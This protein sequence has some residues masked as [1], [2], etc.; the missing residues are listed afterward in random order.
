[1]N[2]GGLNT[3][4]IR[5][6]KLSE[7]LANLDKCILLE[8][9]TEYV[10]YHNKQRN[11]GHMF[12][13][14]RQHKELLYYM[15]YAKS[16]LLTKITPQYFTQLL[17]WRNFDSKEN[18]KYLPMYVITTYMVKLCPIIVSDQSQ[19]DRGINFWLGIMEHAARNGFPYGL[20]DASTGNYVIPKP[21]EKFLDF[22][23]RVYIAAYGR[24][25]KDETKTKY[26]FF[27][28]LTKDG[29]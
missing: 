24:Q 15:E 8:A 25:E 28:Y 23:Q 19:T 6:N 9:T 2:L 26:R 20:L 1:M 21:K 22:Y 18:T 12:A 5:M 7:L 3:K 17:V 27:A 11:K 16:T 4:H 10:L 13:L 14:D 29:K